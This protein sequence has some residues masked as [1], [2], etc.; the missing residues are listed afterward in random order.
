MTVAIAKQSIP[1]LARR[2]EGVLAARAREGTEPMTYGELA[3]AVSDG[4]RKYTATDMG[5]LLKHVG[6]RGQYSWSRP[7]L[8][9]AVNETG[10]PSAVDVDASSNAADPAEER[11]RWHPRIARHFDLDDE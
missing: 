2:A 10:K 7:L 9:W 5:T 6:E 8:A 4:D 1:E 3:E 11:E